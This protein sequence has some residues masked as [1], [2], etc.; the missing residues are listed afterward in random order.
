MKNFAAGG[1]PSVHRSSSSFVPSRRVAPER[2]GPRRVA[3]ERSRPRRVAPA[4]LRAVIGVAHAL[5]CAA[6]V[7]PVHEARAATPPGPLDREIDP[8]DL[9]LDRSLGERRTDELP[10]G[11]F[12]VGASATLGL[13]SQ[14]PP[15][16]GALAFLQVPFDRLYGPRRMVADFLIA[17]HARILAQGPAP[18][19]PRGV[20]PLPGSSAPLPT[21]SPDARAAR[22]PAPAP[23]SADPA[24][25][26]TAPAAPA[27]P[28]LTPDLARNT[29]QAA[30]KAAR[31]DEADARLDALASRA[32]SSALLPELR[33]RATRSID[34]SQSLT[35]TEYDPTR[36]T[37]TSSATTWLEARATFRLDRLVFADDEIAV[38]RQRSVRAAER[39]RLVAKVLELLD[40]W[41]R[42]RASASDPTATPA[43]RSRAALS[44]AAS[45]ASLD[46]LTNGWFSRA[47]ATLPAA[48]EERSAP[49]A[50]PSAAPSE[51]TDTSRDVSREEPRGSAQPLQTP[52][53]A[54][55]DTTRDPP[56][57]AAHPSSPPPPSRAAERSK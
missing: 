23:A 24:P 32:K 53:S 28:L 47:I 11:S 2:S 21:P 3:P 57:D 12:A 1:S 52:R 44:V 13:S 46:V 6:I 29:V 39:S 8:L 16:F 27:A 20:A 43:A 14:A 50:A 40:A 30:C 38:E 7:A 34:E 37:A 36:T 17:E 49:A 5:L 22:A 56:H 10:P 45:E 25:A 19:L 26:T 35:P 4:L 42:S 9:F 54:M 55:H 15:S 33:L 48:R 51:G 31:L 18:S 41:Q